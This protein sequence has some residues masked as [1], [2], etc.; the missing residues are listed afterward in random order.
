MSKRFRKAALM[1]LAEMICGDEPY[2]EFFPYRTSSELTHFF[3]DLELHYVHDGSTRRF[4]VESVL[5]EL[6]DGV[7]SFD[8]MPADDMI[9]VI[10]YLLHFDHFIADEESKREHAV[11]AANRVLKADG[12][13]VDVDPTN[14][15]AIL[16]PIH[17]EFVSTATKPEESKRLITFSP[18]VFKIPDKSLQDKLVSVMMPFAAEFNDTYEAI[19]EA[20]AGAGLLCRRADDIWNDSTVIQDI[21]ELIYCARIVIVDF[22]GKNSNVLYETG[23]AHTLGKHVV[24]ITQSVDDVPFDLRHHRVLKYL[25]NTEG[26][27]AL[28]KGLAE[29]LKT[30]QSL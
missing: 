8:G 5:K 12:F 4:W 2:N 13:V 7:V 21:F 24:P 1:R 30:L 3:R 15:L 14:D 29:R 23:I 17:G 6:N 16:R 28:A 20:C 18:Q 9:R 25:P 11:A 27:K 19:K 10:G 26:Y 22:T